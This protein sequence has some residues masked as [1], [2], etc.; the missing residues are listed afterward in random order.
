MVRLTIKGYSKSHTV[1]RI[2]MAKILVADD[3]PAS[4]TIMAKV[5]EN[6]GHVAIRASDGIRA[7][8][9][10]DDNPDIRLL[11]TDIVMPGLDGR[12]LLRGLRRE[13]LYTLLPAIVISGGVAQDNVLSEHVRGETDAS[14][15]SFMEK[16]IDV[17]ELGRLIKEL[18]PP[19]N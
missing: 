6:T 9:I 15:V 14:L 2:C 19:Q 12:D 1:R 3:D 13:G 7:H 10:L 4:R 18:V 16:P 17:D 11:I 5:V 8:T